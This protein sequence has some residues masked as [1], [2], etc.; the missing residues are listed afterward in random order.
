MVTFKRTLSPK[1]GKKTTEEII[2]LITF[3]D[4]KFSF[5]E[6]RIQQDIH[7]DCSVDVA[8]MPDGKIIAKSPHRGTY[9]ED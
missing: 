6:N 4:T 2:D 8:L 9:I 7:F 1:F 5:I 3:Y